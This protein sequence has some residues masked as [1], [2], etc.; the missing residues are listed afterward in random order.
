M[1]NK[2]LEHYSRFT[3]K[4]PSIAE[5]VI[6]TVRNLL[7]KPVF[8]AVN[9]NWLSELS[10]VTKQY[11]NTIHHSTKMTPIQASKKLNEKI[12]Y[13]NLKDNREVRKP[14]FKLG[15]LVRTA[16]IKRV[17]SKGDSTSYSYKKIYNNRS[18]S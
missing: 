3:D 18:Y 8:L 10:S 1:K 11:N 14:K 2:N 6:R 13:N 9:A 12:V 7:K 5:R 4:G 17:F 15:D 16:D